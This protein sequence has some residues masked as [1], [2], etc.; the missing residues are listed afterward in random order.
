MFSDE[1][2]IR[3]NTFGDMDKTCVIYP[4]KLRHIDGY[5][6]LV[7]LENCIKHIDFSGYLTD[8]DYP[9]RICFFGLF[10]GS[11]TRL[12]YSYKRQVTIKQNDVE[13]L[14]VNNDLYN[15][16]EKIIYGKYKMKI[17]KNFLLNNVVYYYVSLNLYI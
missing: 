2:T 10:D 3:S 9:W 17:S 4:D 13:V 5:V 11:N 12:S 15:F 1:S 6:L 16:G 8:N 7:C 14:C